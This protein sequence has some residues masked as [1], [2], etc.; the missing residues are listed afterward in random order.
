MGREGNTRGATE[1]DAGSADE[2]DEAGCDQ[3]W[4]EEIARP[5]KPALAPQKSAEEEGPAGAAPEDGEEKEDEVAEEIALEIRH[6]RTSISVCLHASA[7]VS[8]L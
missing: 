3:R 2:T 8:T 5:G 7:G 1:A 6:G 4:R